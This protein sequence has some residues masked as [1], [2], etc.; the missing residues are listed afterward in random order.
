VLG[1]LVRE[2]RLLSLY[3]G[4]LSTLA[5]DV[6]YSALE[7][8]VYRT[9][10][11]GLRRRGARRAEQRGGESGGGGTHWRQN[12]LAAAVAGAVAAALTAPVDLVRTRL[13]E[14]QSAG[15]TVSALSIPTR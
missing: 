1:S 6:P 13:L 5:R 10:Q 14:A 11:A 9:V 2:G 8:G 15:G 12:L 3:G 4:Y 7:L